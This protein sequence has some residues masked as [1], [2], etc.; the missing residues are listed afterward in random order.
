MSELKKSRVSRRTFLKGMGVAAGAL[1]L[2]SFSS[3]GQQAKFIAIG[4]VVP[5]TGQLAS[6]GPRF[7][8]A[9]DIAVNDMNAVGLP[10]GFR[11]NLLVRDS[12][13]DAS[14]GVASAQ[15]L[16][17]Q[18]VPAVFGAAASGVTIPVSSVTIPNEVVLISPSATSPAISTLDDNDFVFRTAPSDAL[19]GIV[20]AELAIK[21]GYKKIAII[22]RNDAYGAGLQASAKRNF[23]ALGGTVT[24]TP[25]YDPKTTDFSAEIAAATAGNP[26][27]ISLITFD[28]GEPLIIQLETA[29]ASNWDL[30]VDGNKNQDLITRLAKKIG[31][32]KLAGKVGTAPATAKT[33][34][35]SIF[36]QKYEAVLNEP[37][38][39]FTP[40]SYDALAVVGL[41]IAKASLVNGGKAPTGT[42]I[43]DQMRFVANPP[44]EAV[45]VGEFDKAFKT[46]SGG[47]DINYQGAAGTIDFDKNGD[48]VGP[49]GTWYIDKNGEI[50]EL[51]VI[52][53]SVGKQ[54]PTCGDVTKLPP[55]S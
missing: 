13:T 29:G 2:G 26:D 43:R 6:F 15:T 7:Q 30:L 50:Q 37:P 34:G 11:L 20:L 40:N 35:G 44:G 38:F 21:K 27:A 4:A 48:V 1:T 22:A 31:V 32:A 52:D 39:V 5:L 10:G 45:T 53:C 28:E 41:A 17:A 3:F 12:A 55:T 54:G 8:K 51:Q 47:G 14:T 9:A 33:Q 24:A 46:L 42:E 16:V 49:I 23:E 25:L 18:G 19:Q 36:K